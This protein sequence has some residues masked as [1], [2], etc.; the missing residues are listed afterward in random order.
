MN[1]F[2]LGMWLWS[3]SLKVANV[4]KSMAIKYAPEGVFDVATNSNLIIHRIIE[5]PF[6]QQDLGYEWTGPEDAE[7]FLV[8]LLERE[9]AT[10]EVEWYFEGVEEAYAWVRHF[11]GSIE[12]III[13]GDT[14]G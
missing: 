6:T 1:R 10:E 12:P 9:G 2:N 7:C 14:Y 5:G 8:V 3:S 4:G 13:D 11:K